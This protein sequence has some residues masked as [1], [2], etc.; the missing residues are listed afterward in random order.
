MVVMI[1]IGILARLGVPRYTDMKQRAMAASII[2]DVRALRSAAYLYYADK[3]TW[4]AEV[5]AGVLPTELLT[6][7]PQNFAFTKPNYQLDWDVWNVSSTQEAMVGVTITAADPVVTAII[8]RFSQSG[9]VPMYSGNTITLLI[10]GSLPQ[11]GTP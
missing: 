9:Y 7:L 11:G 1:V 3:N 10:S 8:Y 4:P 6:Y 5:G 2:G